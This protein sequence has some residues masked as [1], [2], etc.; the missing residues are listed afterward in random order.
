MFCCKSN[1]AVVT[2][3]LDPSKADDSNVKEQAPERSLD[4]QS[5]LNEASDDKDKDKDDETTKADDVE[6]V[7]DNT[8]VSKSVDATSALFQA[9]SSDD[10][11]T[12]YEEPPKIPEGSYVML[13]DAPQ[14][15]Y[16]PWGLVEYGPKKEWKKTVPYRIGTLVWYRNNEGFSGEYR[17]FKWYIPGVVEDYVFSES[18]KN[19]VIGY[20]I[21]IEDA[22]KKQRIDQ[23]FLDELSS[24]TPVHVMLRWDEK[25]PDCPVEGIDISTA[26]QKSATDRIAELVEAYGED[27][28]FK[29]AKQNGTG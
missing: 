15:G 10:V 20:K 24:A 16:E 22:E 14:R 18:D 13:P 19:E 6:K 3:D 25:E 21:G 27:L 7:D 29:G 9:A 23:Y 17:K 26:A 28:G 12:V 8:N 2:R 5:F 11:S 4:Y 1:E